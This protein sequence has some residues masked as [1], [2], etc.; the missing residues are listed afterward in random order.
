MGVELH[1]LG[2]GEKTKQKKED[3]PGHQTESYDMG[4]VTFVP[5]SAHLGHLQARP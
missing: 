2:K 4:E 3:H 5:I 1:Y